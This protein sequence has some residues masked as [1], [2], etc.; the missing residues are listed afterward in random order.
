MRR[1]KSYSF[2]CAVL[3][4]EAR[5]SFVLLRSCDLERSLITVTQIYVG[6]S[7]QQNCHGLQV[8]PID[9][10]KQWRSIESVFAIY[11]CTIIQQKSHSIRLSLRRGGKQWRKVFTR[12]GIS[13]RPTLNQVLD[14]FEIPV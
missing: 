4:Q 13:V 3:L 5:Y 12:R 11:F 14:L 1:R 8:V 2:L 6:T 10:T 7:R 9:S